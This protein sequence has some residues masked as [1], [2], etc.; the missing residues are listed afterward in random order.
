M[1]YGHKKIFDATK[2]LVTYLYYSV[3]KALKMT[4]IILYTLHIEIHA[5]NRD[6][7]WE[8]LLENSEV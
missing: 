7:Y 5:L 6:K 4:S 1:S 3:Y 2:Y 8:A